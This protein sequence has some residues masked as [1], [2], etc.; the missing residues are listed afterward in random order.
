M[1]IM[2]RC[3]NTAIIY[4]WFSLAPQITRRQKF[5]SELFVSSNLT[6]QPTRDVREVWR[7]AHR[8]GYQLTVDQAID[9]TPATSWWAYG[10]W[11]SF[12]LTP[13]VTWERTWFGYSGLVTAC[14]YTNYTQIRI[15]GCFKDFYMN[16][17]ILWTQ[18]LSYYAFQM[19]FVLLCVFPFKSCS[20]YGI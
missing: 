13:E 2:H 12:S 3:L 16:F 14:K 18:I 19:R 10:N 7:G 11:V 4:L 5:M 15:S 17:W 8:T 1:E 6:V 20:H 9:P